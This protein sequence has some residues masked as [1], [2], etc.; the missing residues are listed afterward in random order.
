[1]LMTAFLLRLVSIVAL[2]S[3]LVAAGWRAETAA[4]GRQP[5]QP[6][7]SL[8]TIEVEGMR[9]IGLSPDGRLLAAT[10]FG[11]DELCVYTVEPFAEQ[12]CASMEPLVAGLRLED[13]S[14]SPDS[15]RLV[16][17]ER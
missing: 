16:L 7:G 15:T 9:P 8:Q 4:Q 2:M 3:V 14:W 6:A 1:V 13:V 10:D 11:M 12:V 17:A 5:A